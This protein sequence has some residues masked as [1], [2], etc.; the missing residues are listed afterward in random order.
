MRIDEIRV[1][2][3]EQQDI[4]YRD[5]HSRLIP[6]VPKEAIIGVRTP[7]LRKLAK[8]L[9][10]DESFLSQLPHKYY[11]ENQLHAFIIS[12]LS[13]FD[14]AVRRLDEFLPFVD[15][16]AT[17]DQM[18]VKVFRK[19]TDELLPHIKRWISSGKTYTVR[20]AVGCLMEFYLDEKFRPEYL[21]LVAEIR[22]EEYYVRMM[23]AWYFA[24]ALAKQYDAA[25]PYIEGRR[26]DEWTHCKTIQKAIESRRLT[27]EQKCFL[28][29]LKQKV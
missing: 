21:E 19:H 5:F 25:L 8:E 3:S 28:R 20:F 13:D 7:E 1:R 11:E 26:L 6:N 18:S 4:K 2:L 10:A 12:G 15:N 27:P 29:T 9:G 17:C 23:T 22:S 16:W 24:T 14:E